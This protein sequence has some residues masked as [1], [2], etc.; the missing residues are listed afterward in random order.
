MPIEYSYLV[1]AVLVYLVM[2]IVQAIAGSLHHGAIPLL[3]A[4]DN[5]KPDSVLMG[6]TKRATANMLENMAL[7]APL[8]IVAVESGRTN[9]LTQFG[10]ALFLGARVVYAPSYWFGIPLRP[11]AWL[12]GVVGTLIIASQVLPFSGAA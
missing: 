5:L 3:G 2:I 10:A 11:F 7:F 1:G 8:V 4:R 12:A 6:R 9:D